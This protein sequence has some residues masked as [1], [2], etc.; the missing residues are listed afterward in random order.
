MWQL[1]DKHDSPTRSI[2]RM[3]SST[4]APAPWWIGP[5][6]RRLWQLLLVVL[7]M[8]VCWLAFSPAPPPAADTGWDKANHALAFTVLAIV[9]ELAFWPRRR[10]AAVNALG[11]LAFGAFIELV[12]SQIPER[13]GEWPDLLADGTGVTIGLALVAVMH[14][15]YIRP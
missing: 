4:S 14:R 7:G 8:A 10:R 15:L 11:L 5:T 12:Q 3:R 1:C 9:A 2:G 6:A 13:T